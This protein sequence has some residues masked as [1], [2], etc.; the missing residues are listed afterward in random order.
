MKKIILN[1]CLYAIALLF[2]TS[3]SAAVD[4]VMSPDRNL[5]FRLEQR[6]GI[7]CYT[8]FRGDSA[9]LAPSRLGLILREAE[10]SK[11]LEIEN[12]THSSFSEVWQQPWGEETEVDN[13]YNEMR[14]NLRSGGEHPLKLAL[15]VRMFND[16]LGFRYEIPGGQGLD[17][18]TVMDEVTEF[19]LPVDA[20][21]WS[22]P[23][24]HTSYYEGI[25]RELPVS[26]L[27]TVCTPLTMKVS[28][29]LYM[30]IHEAALTDYAKMNLAPNQ[31]GGTT[32]RAELTP[33][34]TG[35]KVFAGSS[36]TTPWRT[37][38]VADTPGD[39]LLSRLMLNL[40]EPCRIEDTS[41]IEPG[42]Y[43]G[44][45]W[46]IHMEKYTWSQGNRHGA[47][48]ANIKRYIDF[49][50][51]HGFAGVLAEGWNTGWDGDWTKNGNLFSFTQ[52]TPDFDLEEVTRYA[53]SKGVRF[54]A[55]TETGG[56]ASNLEKQMEDAFSL[57]ER[58]GINSVKTGYVG[59]L[60]DGKER[61]DSQYGVRHYR[62]V[63][64]AA[65]RHHLMIDNHEPVMPT[66]LQRTYPN[67]MTQEGVRG[68][69]YNAWAR[70]GG[71]PPSHTV[72]LP[73][74]R[75]LAGPMDYTPNVFCHTNTLVA[76]THPGTTTAGELALNVILFSPLQMAAD[77]IENYE[78]LPAFEFVTACPTTWAQTVVPEAEIGH[79]V[80][81][82]RKERDGDRWFLGA[83]TNEHARVT[84]ISLDFLDKGVTYCARI[85][86]DGEKADYKDN[87]YPVDITEQTVTA[88]DVLQLPLASGGGAAVIFEK[89]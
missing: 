69:E 25:Y 17:S 80:T 51:A 72:T 3:C 89:K 21:S 60:I 87:P 37:V 4:E 88:D 14:V 23:S 8:L 47:T 12:V 82:A 59:S 58:M 11:K 19:S 45:W 84:H 7:L 43:I 41:W 16:G 64:E 24:N 67:L 85:F 66:G 31:V 30:T 73:F 33:W 49:A 29:N 65:A 44:I 56:A 55:H 42:R 86:A 78:N 52:S 22:I 9:V 1:V 54:I 68:Q 77:M 38:I 70:D 32:L 34:S 15:V 20:T 2:I 50:A 61:H 35:E 83:H 27:D 10:L 39:L 40:N 76:E 6:D 28:P 79:Y 71:N 53:A 36:L 13:T 5:R 75:G 74:T 57:Y 46:A 48:T 26:L 62:K 18:L 63:I 81:M